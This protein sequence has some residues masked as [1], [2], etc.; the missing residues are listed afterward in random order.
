MPVFE[1]RGTDQKGKP[2][3]GQIQAENLVAAKVKLK[4]SR[5]FI[6]ALKDKSGASSRVSFFSLF[7][8]SKVDIKT[9]CNTT[10]ML[11]TLLKAG[12]PLVD[13]IK[14][15]SK[16]TPHHVLKNALTQIHRK[17]NEGHSFHKSL[18]EYPRIFDAS[19]V[20]MCEA[21]ESSGTLDM[22]LAKLA[23]F[24]EDQAELVS[25]V[26]STLAY[27]ALI[28]CFTFGV[29][30]FLFT[31][32]I[33]K[34]TVLFEEEEGMTLPWYTSFVMSSSEM[35]IRSWPVILISF[36][37][38][39]FFAR[40]WS[41]TKGG[42]HRMD[43]LFLKLPIFGELVRAVSISRFS[44][45]LG[46]LLNGGVPMLISM[47]ITQNTIKNTI[48]K[49]AIINA[50]SHIRE[51]ESIARPLEESG[52]FPPMTIQMIKVGEKTGELEN[53]LFKI[54]DTYDTQ[55]RTEVDTL[56]SLLG[57]VMVIFMGGVVGFIIFSVMVPIFGMYNQLGS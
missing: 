39:V 24:T 11:A 53:M 56:T 40:Q 1:Y 35:V 31:Y 49:K 52:Q 25:K 22:V 2:V 30:L 37:G 54:S 46:T 34:I 43:Y 6:M 4:K 5:I 28:I 10:R 33:P 41:R 27:P 15:I 8:R 16:Q 7:K 44:R 32:I 14:T 3:R 51:G 13:A 17:I 38:L 19:Y 9:L 47:Q 23:E 48:L 57:P 20:S 21:G 55:V 18:S 45:T 42:R 29:V 12:V 50:R 36:F 26:R